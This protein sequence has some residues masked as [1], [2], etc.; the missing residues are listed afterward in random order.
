VFNPLLDFDEKPTGFNKSEGGIA[1][2][3]RPAINDGHALKS[4]DGGKTHLHAVENANKTGFWVLE[5]LG[6]EFGLGQK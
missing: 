4:S 1:P 5:A 2:D 3:G 6:D